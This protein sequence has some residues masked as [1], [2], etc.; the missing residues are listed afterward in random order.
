MDAA[1]LMTKG[2]EKH[3]YLSHC[4]S[5]SFIQAYYIILQE[6]ELSCSCFSASKLQHR[7]RGTVKG[8]LG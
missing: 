8:D 7:G 6:S 2:G 5:I 4:L 1:S 3:T